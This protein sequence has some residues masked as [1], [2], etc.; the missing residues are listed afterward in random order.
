[1]GVYGAVKPP[2]AD[3]DSGFGTGEWDYGAGVTLSKRAGSLLFLGDLGYWVF[4]DLV[5]LELQDPFAYSI[6]LGRTLASGRY[7]VVGS[8]SGYTEIVDGVDGPIE[9]S[10]L[11]SRNL[12][13]GRSF[14]LTVSAGLTDSAPD[15]SL[16]AGWRL[17]L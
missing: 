4:G 15:Y 9:A 17:A 5:D 11:V 3:E 16:A 10:F 2:L 1:M 8:V 14:N 12:S 7:S 13:A 6:G